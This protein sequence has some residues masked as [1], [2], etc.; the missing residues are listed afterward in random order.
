MADCGRV[1]GNTEV[2][3]EPSFLNRG[4]RRKTA[5]AVARATTTMTRSS[6]GL[7]GLP[8]R[9]PD[10]FSRLHSAAIEADRD[11]VHAPRLAGFLSTSATP[12]CGGELGP[13]Y[14]TYSFD[15]LTF[16]ESS[17]ERTMRHFPREASP[18]WVE[19]II[20]KGDG[21]I[22]TRKYRI[23]L[24]TSHAMR[25]CPLCGAPFLASSFYSLGFGAPLRRAA[26]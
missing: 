8:S 9:V 11:P 15:R 19:V 13:E 24:G 23:N 6:F 18:F 5:S 17:E 4:L 3:A 2:I 25:A 16:V 10:A 7:H 20:S 14:A 22:E 21:R 26:T 1:V 12:P